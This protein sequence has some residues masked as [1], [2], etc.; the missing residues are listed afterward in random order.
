MESAGIISRDTL[1][2]VAFKKQI[3]IVNQWD[4]HL[5]FKNYDMRQTDGRGKKERCNKGKDVWAKCGR[6]GNGNCPISLKKE[7]PHGIE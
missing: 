4:L 1:H 2:N 3:Q 7:P 6:L 5:M